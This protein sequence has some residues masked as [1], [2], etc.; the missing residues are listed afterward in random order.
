[1]K[2]TVIIQRHVTSETEVYKHD[3]VEECRAHINQ[4]DMFVIIDQEKIELVDKVF[5]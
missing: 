1:M 4:G 5:N 2:Y 3:T